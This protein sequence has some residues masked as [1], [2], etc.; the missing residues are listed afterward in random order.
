M[1]PQPAHIS[2]SCRSVSVASTAPVVAD[3]G[4]QQD[5]AAVI[6]QPRMS[7]PDA[8]KLDDAVGSQ[9]PFDDEDVEQATAS[10]QHPVVVA[11]RA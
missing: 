8:D 4:G 9:L 1:L 5:A 6:S 3:D 10:D 2:L 7:P 11:R